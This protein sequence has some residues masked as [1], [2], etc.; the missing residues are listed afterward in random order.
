M[1]SKFSKN[2]FKKG[3]GVKR[4]NR[5]IRPKRGGTRL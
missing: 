3:L 2:R 5:S 1:K 4:R